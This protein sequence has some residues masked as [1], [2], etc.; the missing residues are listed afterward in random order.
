MAVVRLPFLLAVVPPNILLH[1]C[2]C[3]H[4]GLMTQCSQL[5]EKH[6]GRLPSEKEVRMY[7]RYNICVYFCMKVNK[8]H[9]LFE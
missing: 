6:L 8:L 4:A 7:V 3:I 2:T 1:T 9:T 5:L